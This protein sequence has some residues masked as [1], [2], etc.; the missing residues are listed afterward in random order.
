MPKR[1]VRVFNRVHTKCLLACA[2]CVGV[3]GIGWAADAATTQYLTTLSIEELSNITIT[4]VSRRAEKL[5]DAAASIYVITS[6]DIRRSGALTLPEAL[7]LAPNLEVARVTA[8]Q[9]AIS[10]RGFSN[11]I[12][13][14]LLVLVDGRTVY[15]PLFSTVNWD[16]QHV[17]LQDVERIEVISGPGATLWGANAVN[18][19]INVITRKAQDS[20]G[21]IA[22]IGTGNQESALDVRHGGTFGTDGHF[23][24]YAERLVQRNSVL[25]NSNNVTDGWQNSQLGFRTDWGEA[26]R[27]FTVQGDAYRAGSESG[28]LGAADMSGANLLV[29][30]SEQLSNGTS[31]ELQSYYD[32]T[33]RD[34]P[35]SYRDQ[36]NIFDIQFQQTIPLGNT[37]KLMWGAGYR[38][39]QDSTQAHF[40][41]LILLVQTFSPADRSL[42]WSDLFIQDEIALSPSIDLTLGIK[43]ETNIY[44][45]VEYLPSARFAW[46]LEKDQLMWG[47]LS[48]AVRA[49]ARLD[50]DY[51]VYLALPGRPLI[52]VIKGGPDFQSE[53]ADV[54]EIGYRAQPTST[55][56]FS[57]TG[58]YTVYDKLRS[59]QPPPAVVQNMMDG[60]THGIEAWAN[61]QPTPDW[62][63]SAGLMALRQDLRIKPGSLDPTGPS[64]QGNDPDQ[65][66]QLRSAWNLSEQYQLDLTV[67]HVSALPQPIVPAYTAWDGRFNWHLHKNLDIALS[68][69]NMLDAN[70]HAEFGAPASRSEFRR[71]V[72]LQAT[73]R[74]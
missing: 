42:Q 61:Y 28:L 64:A 4:S 57:I 32:H 18:G 5:S 1:R 53:T 8:S 68:A 59:G 40:S 38:S 33:E 44:T 30:W 14:K 13:N 65:T 15:T 19:V 34:D 45:G 24:V 56:S 2:A 54:L 36:A 50:R 3:P 23:R 27:N 71:T 6:E 55:L 46:K 73:W 35:M 20:Q 26:A 39:A 17:M 12:G 74:M 37:Q 22:S 11:G 70:G 51:N 48:H 7:R 60:T 69:Q 63:L 31:L 47:A 10:A 25:G 21:N 41:P 29:R 62:R 9:Y 72:F 43:A 16:V 49:P 66:W 52:P 58:F 67:R